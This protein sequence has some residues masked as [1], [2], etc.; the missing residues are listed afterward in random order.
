MKIYFIN[1]KN[2]NCG[3]YQYGLRLWDSIK[4]SKLQISYFEIDNFE[5]FKSLDFSGVDLIIFNFIEGGDLGPFSW[6]KR[7]EVLYV[8]NVLNIKTLRI[9]HTK[10]SQTATF[11]YSLNQDPGEGLPRPLYNYDIS[12][13]KPI[14]DVPHIC[15]FGFA[16]PHKG[17]DDLVK[18]VNEEFEEAVV[19]LHITNAYYGDR[20]GKGQMSLIDEIKKIPTKEKIKVNITTDF[21]SNDQILDFVYNN[22]ILVLAYKGGG[23]PSSLPDYPISAN[24]PFAV[25]SMPTFKHVYDENIDINKHTIKEILRYNKEVDYPLKFRRLWSQEN[26]VI[27]FEQAMEFVSKIIS[28]ITYSQVHQDRFALKLIGKNGY[29]LDIGCGWDHSGM[30]SN[31]FLLEENGWTGICIDGHAPSLENRKYVAKSA[32]CVVAK[33]PQ[34]SLL[35]ILKKYEAPKTIDYISLDIDPSSIVGLESF[36]FEEY[37]FKVMTFEHDSYSAGQDQKEKSYQILS[38][39]GY[40]RLCDNIRVP[41][42]MGEGKYFEDWWINPKYFSQEFIQNNTFEKVLGSYVVENIKK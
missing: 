6:Y 20:D 24:T 30:N 37:E 5:D 19:N 1:S 9:T 32:N 12:K 18:K 7:S 28:S 22:D 41:E 27:V 26:T 36:P 15:S 31:T 25:T 17:F 14:H 33:L 11:D 8:K 2:K 13:P 39:K 29:F 42:S 23:D 34:D 38:S 10:A 16:G 35:E 4:N 40:Y 3:V 21:L